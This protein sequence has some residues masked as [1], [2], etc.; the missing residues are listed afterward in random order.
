MLGLPQKFQVNIKTQVNVARVFR[1]SLLSFCLLWLC[2]NS[3][4]KK[5]L[6]ICICIYIYIYIH[7]Y[8][9]IYIYIY[10]CVYIFVVSLSW[11]SYFNSLPIAFLVP[12]FLI[13][14]LARLAIT[15]RQLSNQIIKFTMYFLKTLF[16]K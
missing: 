7:I 2:F 16:V 3:C 5:V 10:V 15:I 9:Y 12:H 6:S 14:P 4:F 11:F 8:I 13:K 1:L